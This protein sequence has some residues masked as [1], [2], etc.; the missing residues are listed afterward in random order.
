MT[1]EAE[2]D[3]AMMPELMAPKLMEAALPATASRRS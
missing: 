3:G 1:V 2:I